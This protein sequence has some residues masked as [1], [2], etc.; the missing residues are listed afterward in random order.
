MANYTPAVART[1]IRKGIGRA[2]LVATLV[3]SAAVVATT[4]PADRRNFVACPHCAGHGY[5]AV[6][7]RYL[8]R[9]VVLPGYSDRLGVAGARLGL[10]HEVLVE[11]RLAGGRAHLR[12]YRLNV[13]VCL[14]E[15]AVGYL[16]GAAVAH[17]TGGIRNAGAGSV[18]QHAAAGRPTLQDCGPAWSRA[19]YGRF[20]TSQAATPANAASR[21]GAVPGEDFHIDL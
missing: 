5:R 8:P 12:R 9:R 11:G 17:A 13:G 10:G 20:R 14:F 7:A 16:R 1:L 3:A 21:H 19:Q 2:T 4:P 15:S 6:L 18:V